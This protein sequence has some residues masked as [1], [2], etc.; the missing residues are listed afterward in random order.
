MVLPC[1]PSIFFHPLHFLLLKM[2]RG[3]GWG[4]SAFPALPGG[5]SILR[6]ERS[7]PFALLDWLYRQWLEDRARQN[8]FRQLF[9]FV[10]TRPFTSQA[11]NDKFMH[12]FPAMLPKKTGSVLGLDPT[13][14][15]T[16]LKPEL[17]S[18]EAGSDGLAIKLMIASGAGISMHYLVEPGSSTRTTA[19]AA[20]TP[21]FKH[22]KRR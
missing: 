8:Y 3:C 17:A 2:G 14:T 21:T 6:R 11:E 22:F 13:E 20:G 7:I 4:R 9:S 1:Q 12:A 10:L 5:R 15:L 18:N 19:E 16:A